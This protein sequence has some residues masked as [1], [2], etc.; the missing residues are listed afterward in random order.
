MA[1]APALEP[2][3]AEGIGQPV[4][5]MPHQEAGLQTKRQTV[6][7][8]PRNEFGI[9]AVGQVCPECCDMPVERGIAAVPQVAAINKREAEHE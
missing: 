7:N 6:G 1:L 4:R 9:P 3:M 8:I 5:R 2:R